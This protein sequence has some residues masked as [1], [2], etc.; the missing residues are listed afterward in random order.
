MDKKERLARRNQKVRDY[1]LDLE[2]KNPKWKLSE[3][4]KDT[5]EQFLPLA[6]ATISSILK[7]SGSYAEA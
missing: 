1:F 6:P 5:A 7:Q 4:L 2:K 3:L